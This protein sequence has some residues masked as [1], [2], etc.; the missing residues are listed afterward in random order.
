MNNPNFMFTLVLISS[1]LLGCIST[2]YYLVRLFNKSDI[3]TIGSTSTGATNVGRLLGKKGFAPTFIIDVSK[4]M[5][6]AIISYQLHFTKIQSLSCLLA[7]I[8]GHIWPVQLRFNGGKGVAVLTGFYLVWNW[9]MLLIALAIAG[10]LL[11]LT[12]KFTLSGLIAM[13]AFPVYG[14]YMHFSWPV[15]SLLS[16]NIAVI[17]W[18]HRKNFGN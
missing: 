8:C 1:Y 6:I 17:Y 14:C 3:R 13:L 4:G 10:I 18:A 16:F 11:L 2:G 15:I 12:K 9:P 7:L 5:L